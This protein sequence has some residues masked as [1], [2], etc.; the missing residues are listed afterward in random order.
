MSK[1]IS[2]IH[3]VPFRKV[4]QRERVGRY[5]I[6]TLACGHTVT[7]S[8]SDALGVKRRCYSLECRAEARKAK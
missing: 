7:V 5:V 8:A 1:V 2:G 3:G 4:V 6:E